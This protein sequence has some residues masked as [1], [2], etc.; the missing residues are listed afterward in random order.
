MQSDVSAGAGSGNGK[1]WQDRISSPFV[2]E[3]D[4]KTR[5]VKFM[6]NRVLGGREPIIFQCD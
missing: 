1:L 3:T 6:S 2:D 5:P 4:K